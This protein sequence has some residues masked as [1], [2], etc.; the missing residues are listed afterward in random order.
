[1]GSDNFAPSD[2]CPTSMSAP[3]ATGSACAGLGASLF[4]AAVADGPR[5][6]RFFGASAASSPRA[7]PLRRRLP[8]GLLC[9]WPSRPLPTV[10]DSFGPSDTRQS[11][12]STADAPRSSCLSL[13]GSTFARS[14][15]QPRRLA[16]SAVLSLILASLSRRLAASG[17][18]R[19]GSSNFAT[20]AVLRQRAWPHGTG[21]D[22]DAAASTPACLE[23]AARCPRHLGCCE[24]RACPAGSAAALSNSSNNCFGRS[25]GDAGLSCGAAP[26]SCRSKGSWTS[27]GAGSQPGASSGGSTIGLPPDSRNSRNLSDLLGGGCDSDPASSACA[28]SVF[29]G[30]GFGSSTGAAGG[31]AAAASLISRNLDDHRSGGG[32]SSSSEGAASSIVFGASEVAVPSTTSF[33]SEGAASPTT[34]NPPGGDV[35]STSFIASEAAASATSVK[36]RGATVSS[37]TSMF[38][39]APASATTF[40]SSA[41]VV[42]SRTSGGNAPEDAA[43]ADATA[44]GSPVDCFSMSLADLRSGLGHSALSADPSGDACDSRRRSRHERCLASTP[45]R[46]L[47]PDRLRPRAATSKSKARAGEHCKHRQR[48]RVGGPLAGRTATS[49]TSAAPSAPP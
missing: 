33:S 49:A 3:A 19:A 36:S 14:A 40:A 20:A 15:R 27:V 48:R 44:A 32:H 26:A 37:T 28:S 43:S 45:T 38:S 8:A 30:C 4:G 12:M 6:L 16:A 9:G 17:G 7:A 18:A 22:A 1:M 42:S 11:S 10:S 5:D 23:P 25:S 35:S 29:S 47:L 41:A 24:G 13:F 21:T 46:N 31:A 34:A 39:E 2:T